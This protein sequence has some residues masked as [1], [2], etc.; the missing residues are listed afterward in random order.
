MDRLKRVFPKHHTKVLAVVLGLGILVHFAFFIIDHAY[1]SNDTG[2]YLVLADNLLQKHAFINDLDQP[3]L[4]RTPGYPALLALFS[5]PPLRVEYLIMVQHGLCVLV[6][7]GLA[8][9]VLKI[10]NSSPIALA[11]ALVLC[12]DLPTITTA[13]QL[14]TETVFTVFIVL[15]S[16]MLYGAAKESTG[17]TARLAVAGLIG[18]GAVLIRPIG[19]LYVVPVSVYLFL[20]LRRRTLRAMVTFAAAF[21]FLPLGWTVRNYLETGYFGVSTIGAGNVLTYRAAGTLAVRQPGEYLANAEKARAVLL[22]QVCNAMG[23]TYGRDCSQ[24][25]EAERAEYSR[26]M[27]M[28]IILG[29][30]PDYLR[31]M[32]L[33]V[34]Y[35]IFGG[36]AEAL[37]QIGHLDPQTARRVVLL[38]SIPEACFAVLG[39]WFWFRRERTLLC[40]IGL[41]IAYFLLVSAGAE[42]YSRFRVPVMPMYA[43]LVGGGLATTMRSVQRVWGIIREPSALRWAKYQD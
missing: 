26:R 17:Q 22:E 39:C 21:L 8:A 7:I 33:G 13:N 9:M 20:V 36:G 2:S 38:I 18:G 40:L 14:L 3:E 28:Q 4:E 15:G 10:T 31:S 42:A 6:A 30:I 5:I 37:S 23:R 35:I 25:P 1:Y 29:N 27:G 12:L 24:L 43:L 16:W 11:S 41:T 19:L 34:A 32:A